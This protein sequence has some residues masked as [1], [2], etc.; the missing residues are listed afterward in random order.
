M[1]NND[2]NWPAPRLTPEEWAQAE[3]DTKEFHDSLK[4]VFAQGM[5][6]DIIEATKLSPAD[7]F[8][9]AASNSD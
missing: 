8:F 4:K 1:F 3:K 7:L 9:R 6:L 5:T 2:E